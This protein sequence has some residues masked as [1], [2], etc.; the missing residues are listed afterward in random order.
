MLSV[1]DKTLFS[2]KD[3]DYSLLSIGGIILIIIVAY[4]IRFIFKRLIK[5]VSKSGKVS[6][7]QAFSII[8]IVSYLIFVIAILLVLSAVGVKLTAL[9][10]GSAA[11]LVGI[12]FG[13]QQ[14][15]LDLISGF[16]LLFDS[17]INIGDVLK[18]PDLVGKVQR[19]GIRTTQILT[20]DNV[21]VILPNSHVSNSSVTNLSHSRMSTRFRVKVGV[22]YGSD[23]DKVKE[24]LISCAKSHPK[25]ESSPEPNVLF[26][27]FG[28]SSLDFELRFWSKEIFQI[29]PVQSD[30]RFAIDKKFREGGITIPFP[31]RDLHIKDRL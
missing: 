20:T 11:L 15:F 19:I 12:G 1:L 23:L 24:I 29:E 21:V 17:N 16:I 7:E 30:I 5:K 13:L 22:S 26:R 4:I 28:E 25:V 6:E 18:T 8:Q 31:Q 14:L 3:N 9:L 2:I 10:V 27:D